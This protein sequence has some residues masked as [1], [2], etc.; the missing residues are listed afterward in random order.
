MKSLLFSLMIT[1]VLNANAK[2]ITPPPVFSIAKYYTERVVV[3]TTLDYLLS[4][5]LDSFN[6]KPVDSLLSVLPTNYL[7]MKI[8][9]MGNLRSANTLQIIYPN[10]IGVLIKV[11]DFTHMNPHGWSHEWDLNLFKLERIKC[12]EIWDG[13]ALKNAECN[14]YD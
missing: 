5:N 10:N 1:L 3:D 9:G 4:L 2:N 13:A 8:I 6:Q 12:T 7:R 11:K 14:L